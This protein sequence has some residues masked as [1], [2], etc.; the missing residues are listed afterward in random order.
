[1]NSL[2]REILVVD[3]SADNNRVLRIN[4]EGEI[5][6]KYS[7]HAAVDIQLLNYGG[8]LFNGRTDVIELDEKQREKWR[9]SI[10]KLEFI[11]CRRLDNG[12]TLIGD[13]STQSI[14][15]ITSDFIKLW[16]MPFP[17]DNEEDFHFLFRMVRLLKNNNLLVAWYKKSKVAE[18]K[19]NGEIVWELNL[20]GC[21]Y[22][23]L[24]LEN[25]NYLVSTGPGG[26]I[27]E[28]SKNEGVVWEYNMKED[29]HFRDGW[30]AGICPQAN[31]NIVF[32]DSKG[33]K[34]IEIN[35]N[36]E[37]VGIFHEPEILKYPSSVVTI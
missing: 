13:L 8:C 1:M 18:F 23:A 12:N 32:G 7:I 21:P 15:E 36:K 11:C 19:K 17:H 4:R 33:D 31:G 2:K 9:Y 6:W 27:V 30:I 28:V 5:L 22:E 14:Y 20:D 3:H 35:R 34:I 25:G 26:S 24:E 29:L 16:E 10:N 37:I